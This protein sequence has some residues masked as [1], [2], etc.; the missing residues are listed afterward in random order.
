M[1]VPWRPDL[2]LN[3]TARDLVFNAIKR[4][5]T[6]QERKE[7]MLHILWHVGLE[8]QQIQIWLIIYGLADRGW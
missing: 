4:E 8:V 2:C 5:L 6:P 7:F 3:P 1:N